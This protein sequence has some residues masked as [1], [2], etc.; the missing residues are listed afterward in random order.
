MENVLIKHPAAL[1]PATVTFKDPV[2]EH[3][4]KAFIV[5]KPSNELKENNSKHVHLH[6]A[7][8]ID[9]LPKTESR[10]IQRH[11]LRQMYNK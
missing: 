4:F 7:I 11:K 10:K 2:R 8:F 9:T 5:L 6:E 3:I 1:K